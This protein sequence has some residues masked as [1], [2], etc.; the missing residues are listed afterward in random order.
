MT[1]SAQ[2]KQAFVERVK[3]ARIATGIKQWQI[4]DALGMPQGK[5]KQYEVRSLILTI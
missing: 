2:Y 4:A 5:Y 3:A 1:D